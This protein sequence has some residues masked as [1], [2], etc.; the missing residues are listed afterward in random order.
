M[1]V[2]APPSAPPTVEQK[3]ETQLASATS[4]VTAAALRKLCRIRNA[5]LT[6][7]LADLVA[8]GRP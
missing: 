6:T 8:A 7:A 4:P 1:A 3:L 5:T 2:A